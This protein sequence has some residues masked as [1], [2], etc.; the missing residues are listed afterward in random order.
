[1]SDGQKWRKLSDRL[2]LQDKDVVSLG[3][4][5]E[6]V[7]TA[8]DKKPELTQTMRGMACVILETD[9]LF[10]FCESAMLLA[11]EIWGDDAHIHGGHDDEQMD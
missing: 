5:L 6:A 3:D 7:E 4:L 10:I 1:M 2:G 9:D 8:L 11:R